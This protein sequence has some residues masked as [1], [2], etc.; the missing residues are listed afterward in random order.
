MS[1]TPKV[2][3]V[4]QVMGNLHL[5]PLTRAKIA[6]QGGVALYDTQQQVLVTPMAYQG[7]IPPHFIWILLDVEGNWSQRVSS[8]MNP[9][10]PSKLGFTVYTFTFDSTSVSDKFAQS[11][12]GQTVSV[13][14]KYVKD[15]P[16]TKPCRMKVD[17]LYLAPE[18]MTT[19]TSQLH[20]QERKAM[21]G[22]PV[23]LQI[24]GEFK[25]VFDGVKP[26]I[27]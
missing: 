14:C 13:N 8:W 1:V 25:K 15:A 3:P 21:K 4:I 16:T 27:L 26:L 23:G 10:D 2:S 5:S 24:I 20:S 9:A 19:F 18:S 17:T 7:P 22:R 12:Q 6:E 11:V